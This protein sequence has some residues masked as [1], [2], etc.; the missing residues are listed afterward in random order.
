M[1]APASAEDEE[2]VVVRHVV[3]VGVPL[4]TRL[5]AGGA[6]IVAGLI[7]IVGW[8]LGANPGDADFGLRSVSDVVALPDITIPAAPTSIVLGII[9]AALGVW[10]VVRGFSRPRMRWVLT[11]VL[12]CFVV[13]FLCWASTGTPGNAL[14]LPGLFQNTILLATPLV[15][16]ALAGILCE[17]TGVINVAIEGQFLA[18]AFAGAL[19]ASVSHSLGVGLIFA[20]VAGGLMGA[21]LAVFAIR[22]LV[23]QVVLGV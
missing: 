9:V 2:L 11:A 15:L 4:R 14:N 5:L 3:D 23:N 20:L 19:G 6:I 10:H 22:Y 21:L 12:L 13:A 17:R 18:G 7:C 16:G 8:G 1:T